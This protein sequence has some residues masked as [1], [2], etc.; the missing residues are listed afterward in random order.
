M[1]RINV[2]IYRIYNITEYNKSLTDEQAHVIMIK[3]RFII[4]L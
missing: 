2:Y 1:R 4:A 3:Y